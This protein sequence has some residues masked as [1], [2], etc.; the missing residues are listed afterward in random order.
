M[1]AAAAG[2]RRSHT[3]GA[4]RS[5]WAILA[6]LC[7]GLFMILL[8]G[9]IVNIAIP[10]IMTSFDTGLGNVEWV[11]NAYVLLQA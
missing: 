5:P 8:D 11:M 6:V 2:A 10:H 4:A 1:S 3:Q 9:T 7:V